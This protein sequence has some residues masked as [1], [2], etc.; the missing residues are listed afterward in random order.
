MAGGMKGLLLALALI[1][2]VVTAFSPIPVESSGLAK[3]VFFV[4]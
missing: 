3:V 4:N 1:S 2:L